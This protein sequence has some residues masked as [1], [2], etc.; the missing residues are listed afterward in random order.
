MLRIVIE[1]FASVNVFN[2]KLCSISTFRY[3]NCSLSDST[4]TSFYCA[5]TKSLYTKAWTCMILLS[6]CFFYKYINNNELNIINSS[7]ILQYLQFMNV[8]T[9]PSPNHQYWHTEAL[10][11]VTFSLILNPIIKHH[12]LII[13]IYYI[14]IY[15]LYYIITRENILI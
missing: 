9:K 4:S 2:C 15:S 6:M 12:Y 5:N 1:L 13:I 7:I 10:N 14:N 11:C 8:V 3:S